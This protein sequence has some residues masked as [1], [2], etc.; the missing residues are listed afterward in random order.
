M[1]DLEGSFHLSLMTSVVIGPDKVIVT[2]ELLW[3]LF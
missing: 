3:V 1:I 2:I